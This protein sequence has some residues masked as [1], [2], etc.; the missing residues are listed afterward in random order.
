M[1]LLILFLIFIVGTITYGFLK[2]GYEKIVIPILSV[3]SCAILI[4]SL[5]VTV[6]AG[7]VKVA[8]L[9]GKISGDAY[10][11]GFHLTNPL[12]KFESFDLRQKTHK[13]SAGVP[14][15]DKLITE[16]DI[17]V[18]YRLIGSMAPEI[19]RNTGSADALITVHMIPKLRSILREQG[20]GVETSQ[21]FFKESI[22]RQLQETLKIGLANFMA[23]KGVEIQDVLIR[24]ILLPEVIRNSIELTKKREQQVLEQKAEL[25][26]FAT[27]Q[28]QKVKQAESEFEA[29]KLEAQKIKE[30]ADAEAYKIEAINKTLAKSP[31][32]IAL[33]KVEQWNGVLPVYAGG[34]NVPMVDLRN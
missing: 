6:P 17:S 21:D 34:D 28:N 11:E 12:L 25:E 26:R 19:L 30:L 23:P 31:N 10:P 29:A 14:A 4:S 15:E 22:Q 5:I 24:K 2:L 7:H 16:M 32:Y 1:F 3:V 13:E 27:E 8:T 18:Q 20:K 33:K 9:F